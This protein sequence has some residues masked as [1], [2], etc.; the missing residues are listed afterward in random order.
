[1]AQ[2]QDQRFYEILLDKGY[3]WGFIHT[4]A[5]LHGY[6]IFVI[7]PQPIYATEEMIEQR[8]LNFQKRMRE[9]LE[10]AKQHALTLMP[11]FS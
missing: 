5:S 8:K 1:M 2:W 9:S 4:I 11:K 10:M 7:D 3:D 6:G